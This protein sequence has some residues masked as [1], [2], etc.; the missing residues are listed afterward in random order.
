[1][2]DQ[3]Y[4]WISCIAGLVFCIAG[5]SCI[6]G[7]VRATHTWLAS[8][9]L[10]TLRST[11]RPLRS[12]ALTSL[13]GLGPPST[14]L[15]S[16]PINHSSTHTSAC[17][18]RRDG[19]VFRDHS[20]L[21]QMCGSVPP[22]FSKSCTICVNVSAR[23]Y[24]QVLAVVFV[25]SG[26]PGAMKS[27]LYS[28]SLFNLIVHLVITGAREIV[29]TI[30]VNSVAPGIPDAMEPTLNSSFFGRHLEWHPTISP[31]TSS[32]SSSPSSISSNYTTKPSS[33]GQ[34]SGRLFF[35]RPLT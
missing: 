7:F 16:T 3:L 11:L 9:L 15:L 23:E 19:R 34:L 30:I 20:A 28:S 31:T 10:S 24:V 5:I 27:T 18:L 4:C 21:D 17:G 6:A 12:L 29:K 14:P 25:S 33:L 2:L 8:Q 1:M 32:S 22:Q 26:N 35:R 13:P